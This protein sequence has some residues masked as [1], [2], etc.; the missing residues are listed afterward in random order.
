[1]VTRSH[2]NSQ[3][4]FANIN[5]DEEKRVMILMRSFEENGME[6]PR[7]NLSGVASI[8]EEVEN[9]LINLIRAFE[10]CCPLRERKSNHERRG[11]L[12]IMG[13]M[14]ADFIIKEITNGEEYTGTN[15]R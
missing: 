8:D 1:M 12:K 7:E 13:K 5:I 2:V 11:R 4:F 6:D 3:L 10:E 9:M 15:T 14:S